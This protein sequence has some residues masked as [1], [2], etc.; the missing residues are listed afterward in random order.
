MPNKLKRIVITGGPGSGKSTLLNILNKKGFSMSM[1]AGRSIIQDQI[2]IG[3]NALP[4]G[5]RELFA[6]LMLSWELRSWQ[7]AT[8]SNNVHFF[9]RGIP[10]VKGYLSLCNLP[11]P[12][13]LEK[14]IKLFRYDKTVFIAPPWREIFVQDSERKQSFHEAELTY[15]AMM[16]TYRNSGYNLIELPL[17]TAEERVE[18]ILSKLNYFNYSTKT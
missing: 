16:M 4:W 17:S 7:D 18:F 8:T 10:D 1:E 9:D 2:L 13:Y 3:G 11:I 6:D 15:H 12:E 5:D 14:A